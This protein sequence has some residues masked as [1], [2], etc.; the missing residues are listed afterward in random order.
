MD[1]TTCD[2]SESPEVVICQMH[3]KEMIRPPDDGLTIHIR[4]GGW[5]RQLCVKIKMTCLTGGGPRT[6]MS[7]GRQA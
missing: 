6:Y 2:V 1:L 3:A 7:G 5:S 4:C